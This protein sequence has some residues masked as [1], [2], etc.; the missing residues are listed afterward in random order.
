MI[1]NILLCYSVCIPAAILCFFPMKNQLR[2][3]LKKTAVILGSILPV[4]TI[5][6]TWLSYSYSLKANTLLA[7]L[8]AFCYLSYHRCLKVHFSKS[9]GVFFAVLALMSILGGYVDCYAAW[10]HPTFP[11]DGYTR[12]AVLFQLGITI[13]AVL[14]LARPFSKYLSKVI[15]QMDL[16]VVWY[17]TLLFSGGI[18]I[19]DLLLLPDSPYQQEEIVQRMPS[20]LIILTVLLGMWVVMHAIFYTIVS[21]MT[22]TAKLTEQNNLL[23]MRQKYYLARNEFLSD[24]AKLRHDF[25]HNIRAL[26][27]LYDEGDLEA[28]GRYLHEYEASMP[29]DETVF[30]CK[31]PSLNALL[32]HYSILAKKEDIDLNIQ[33]DQWETLPVSDVDLCSIAGNILENAFTAC[34][35]TENRFIQ[36]TYRLEER[37]WLYIVS[38]NSFD[39]TVRQK[40]GRYL[41]TNHRGSGLGLQ[42][43]LSSAEKYGGVAEFSH[44]ADRFFINIAIPLK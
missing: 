22:A 44:S 5:L 13:A 6:T 30:F 27:G 34:K 1:L 37:N 39:G 31:D 43:I 25:L 16:P 33:M 40:D 29:Q 23:E 36:L 24:N 14:L 12:D 11:I 18:F 28:L 38:T 41:S 15:D 32:N 3:S 2:Y 20:I 35:K 21:G 10:Q 8:M 9:L 26:T 42:S 17:I 7:P 19:I 4:T